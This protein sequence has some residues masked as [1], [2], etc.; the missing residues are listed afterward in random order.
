MRRAASLPPSSRQ[1]SRGATRSV[2]S[3]S[4]VS[5]SRHKPELLPS[6]NNSDVI[7][8]TSIP[9][10]LPKLSQPNSVAGRSE[11][12]VLD[13]KNKIWSRFGY[14]DDESARSPPKDPLVWK[15]YVPPKSFVQQ[16]R[17]TNLAAPHFRDAVIA[18]SKSHDFEDLLYYRRL[19]QEKSQNAVQDACPAP[20][21]TRTPSPSKSARSLRWTLGP[22]THSSFDKKGRSRVQGPYS[23]EFTVTCMPPTNWLKMKLGRLPTR[24]FIKV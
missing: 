16:M 3:L 18:P 13:G 5:G 22:H 1:K 12:Q 20:P 2:V 21:V 4:T 11:V 24:P 15:I 8:E 14:Q 19:L 6:R 9:Y 10:R 7:S 17:Q 23:R